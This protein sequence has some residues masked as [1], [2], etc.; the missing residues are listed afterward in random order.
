MSAPRR[1]PFLLIAAL[2]LGCPPIDDDDTT[3][4]DDDDVT[5]DDDDSSAGD[6]DDTTPG[7]DDDTTPGDDDDDTPA[8]STSLQITAPP[9]GS[10]HALFTTFVAQIDGE[11]PGVATWRI[12]GDEFQQEFF[13]VA[14]GRSEHTVDTALWPDG[15]YTITVEA[16]TW[17]LSDAIEVTLL[18]G[19]LLHYP[20]GDLTYEYLANNPTSVGLTLVPSAVSLLQ[21]TTPLANQP[22][23]YLAG[24]AWNPNGEWAI[25]GATTS[26]YPIGAAGGSPWAG[27]IPN[28]P[29][30]PWVTGPYLLYPWGDESADGDTMT[31]D[32]VVKRAFAEPAAGLLH[33]DFYFVSGVTTSA[34]GAPSHAGLQGMLDSLESVFL[35][36]D[37]ALG[38]IRY[39]DLPAGGFLNIS[40]YAEM[41]ALFEQSV[42]GDDRVLNVFVVNDIDLPG[43]DP[44]GV[45][46]HIPGPALLNGTGQSGVAI[47]DEYI[48]SNDPG[49][50]A[51]LAGHEIGH[52][53]GL[54]H[55]S[56][57]GGADHDPLNDTANCCDAGG[58]SATNLMDPYLYG[59]TSI[60]ADQ[61]WVLHRHPLVEL[62][63]PS[64]LPS[65]AAPMAVDGADGLQL[66]GPV[67]H[68]CGVAP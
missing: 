8:P 26:V 20:L 57:I 60:T 21:M 55:C 29:N 38:D 7:D 58:C 68:F 36:A 52:Y 54:Y 35:G 30:V 51:A 49:T 40:S 47:V 37:I 42:T 43:A 44:L 3:A 63:D 24:Y 6:D 23:E 5:S 61:A 15:E 27:G 4:S 67:P 2:V 48:Q 13:T 31:V 66:S 9:D 32:A 50:G 33:L 59:N 22:W 56:E 10:T 17:G 53:L 1:P 45:A 11:A 34:A 65:R 64:Q 19:D 28:H 46:S 62:I 12:D 16:T 14:T 41:T 25:G 39:F 18:N